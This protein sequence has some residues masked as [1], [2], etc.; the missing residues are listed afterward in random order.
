MRDDNLSELFNISSQGWLRGKASEGF[1]RPTLKQFF[2][3]ASS[4][5]E[6]ILAGIPATMPLTETAGGTMAISANGLTITKIGATG[7]FTYCFQDSA[8][9]RGKHYFEATFSNHLGDVIVVDDFESTRTTNGSTAGAYRADSWGVYNSGG[10]LYERTT[11]V[12]F[13]GSFINETIGVGLDMDNK[14]LNYY[15]TTGLVGTI[16][17]LPEAV[18]VAF[19][20]HASGSSIVINFGQNAFNFTVPNGYNSGLLV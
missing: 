18:Y 7:A 11:S 4:S 10:G 6:E 5:F 19:D 1:V 9:T 14:Q 15:K 16:S 17:N 2:S 13:I 12:G 8:I 20:L 3:P